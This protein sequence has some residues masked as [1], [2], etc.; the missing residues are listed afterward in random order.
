M[1]YIP[2]ADEY[3]KSWDENAKRHDD[4]FNKKRIERF[5]HP[6]EI[7]TWREGIANGFSEEEFT[8]MVNDIA[9]DREAEQMKTYVTV[10]ELY[11]KLG[12][13]MVNGHSK[14]FVRIATEDF[15]Y[16]ATK[17]MLNTIKPDN[18]FNIVIEV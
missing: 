2:T 15:S 3:K 14:D 17:D 5:I 13:L 16:I 11:K 18:E 4:W 12:N 6:V 1:S 8:K 7:K 10:E 9:K